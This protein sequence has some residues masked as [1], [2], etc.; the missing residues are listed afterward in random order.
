MYDINAE[1]CA[2][3]F[4]NMKQTE[5]IYIESGYKEQPVAWLCTMSYNKDMMSVPVSELYPTEDQAHDSNVKRSCRVVEM[6]VKLSLRLFTYNLCTVCWLHYVLHGLYYIPL[7]TQCLNH[8][9]VRV[10]VCKKHVSR[11]GESIY[12]PRYL[13]DVITCPCP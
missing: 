2:I 3:R 6:S 11:T 9:G 5:L 13:W 1:T 10:F 7:L 4:K 8:C 12:T